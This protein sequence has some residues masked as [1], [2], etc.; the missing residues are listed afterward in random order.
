MADRR[1]SAPPSTAGIVQYY[2]VNASKI[3]LDPRVVVGAC[4]AVIV[5]EIFLHIL[6]K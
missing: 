2:D 5:V 4:A 1:I 6:F 3:Q